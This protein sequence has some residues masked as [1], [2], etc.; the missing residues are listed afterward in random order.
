METQ[1]KEKRKN[2]R[3]GKKKER[4]ELLQKKKKE[5]A[6]KAKERAKKAEEKTR[7]TSTSKRQT[8]KKKSTTSELSPSNSALICDETTAGQS[9]GS[10]NLERSSND[11]IDVNVCC[12]C[13]VHYDDD[14]LEGSGADWIFCKCGRWLHE[15]CMEDF[16][17]DNEGIEQFCSFC[18]DKYTV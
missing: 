2:E 17:K 6:K 4:E 1:E 3:A 14:V 18:V 8:T 12:M 16:V 7:K 10:S 15:D 5:K 9:N 11:S 13:F